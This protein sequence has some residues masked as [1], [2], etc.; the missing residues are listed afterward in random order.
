MKKRSKRLIKVSAVVLV[1]T[2]MFC[3]GVAYAATALLNWTGR[4]AMTN[5]GLYIEQSAEKIIKQSKLNDTL[6]KEKAELEK[7]IERL[8]QELEDARAEEGWTEKDQQIVDLK[9]EIISK[10]NEVN[11][12]TQQLEMANTAADEIQEKIDRANEKLEAAGI[13]I[14]N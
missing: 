9:N 8:T 12:L 6:T 5:A 13:N 7:E 11:H 4:S 1:S 3:S 14:W 2:I 10:Q